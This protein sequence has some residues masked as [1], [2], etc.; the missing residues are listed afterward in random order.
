MKLKKIHPITFSESLLPA[1]FPSPAND[2]SET[3]LDLNDYL[4]THPAA[5]FFIRVEGD[6]MEGAHITSGDI[7]IVNRALS[8]K[9]GDIIVALI[10]GEF[11]V[12]RLELGKPIRLLPENPRYK[13]LVIAE[14]NDFQIWGV[15]TYVIHRTC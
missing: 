14:A 2:F 11:T 10:D 4:I 8:A 3:K 7:L 6:S 1:G 9:N 12:K 15:V 13:P 5:T